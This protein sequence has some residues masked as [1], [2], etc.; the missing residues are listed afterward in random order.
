LDHGSRTNERYPSAFYNL[1]SEI[2]F[3]L[4]YFEIGQLPRQDIRKHE[5]SSPGQWHSKHNINMGT[6]GSWLKD[7]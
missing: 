2:A 4:Y 7:K 6:L 3:E 5:I 1:S